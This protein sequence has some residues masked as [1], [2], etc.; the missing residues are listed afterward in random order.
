MAQ[1]ST[2]VPTTEL[3]CVNSVLQAAG[4]S[5]I[6]QSELDTPSQDDTTMAVAT[7]RDTLREVLTAAWRFNTRFGV[8]IAP[9]G[10]YTW[11]AS[12]G[13]ST[14]LNVFKKPAGILAWKL[15]AA[16]QNSGA[17]LYEQLS[18][19]YQEAAAYVN[20]L[21]DRTRNRDGIEKARYPYVYLDLVYARDFTDIPEAARHYVATAA[22]IEFVADTTGREPGQ[23]AL[24]KLQSAYRTLVRQEGMRERRN[25]FQNAATW[26]FLGRR[27]MTFGG[28]SRLVYRQ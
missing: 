10:T 1:F 24:L 7:V 22:A 2:I 4:L 14:L 11:V 13:T 21:F 9:A 3:E 28:F 16:S 18:T 12:D 8:E 27:P 19:R 5:P 6:T 17:D 15:S 26:N 23:K 25:I 20:V